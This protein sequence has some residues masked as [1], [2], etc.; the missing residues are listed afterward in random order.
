MAY[1]DVMSKEAK[2]HNSIERCKTASS[3]N[4]Y[5]R[6]KPLSS[7]EGRHR[8]FCPKKSRRLDYWQEF[9]VA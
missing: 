2:K 5:K 6:S 3:S 8:S 1:G 7:T 9:K 4:N